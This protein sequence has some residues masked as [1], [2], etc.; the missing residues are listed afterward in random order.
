MGGNQD[1]VLA[2]LDGVA[3]TARTVSLS[4]V[5][6]AGLPA[7]VTVPA[8]VVYGAVAFTPQGVD[9]TVAATV[10]A[11]HNAVVRTTSLTI[12]PANL[13]TFY[14]TPATIAGGNNVAGVVRLDGFAG[15]GGRVVTLSSPSANVV[16]PATSTVASQ[17]TAKSFT[18]TTLG[19]GSTTPV[20]CSATAGAVVKNATETLT[21]AVVQYAQPST[22]TPT[23]GTSFTVTVR[24]TGKAGPGGTTFTLSD[25]SAFASTPASAT[26]P[27]GQL[28]VAFTVTTSPVG[29]NTP[30][31]ITCVG[32]AGV[33]TA[34]A[35]V[36]LTP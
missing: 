20:T 9:S 12:N 36:T 33:G 19:V 24:L 30:V 34:A 35:N 25:N 2:R 7:T 8:G 14:F 3:A 10:T 16:V 29:A 32:P 28:A 23:G 22:T 26:V 11:T 21:R 13:L 31:T 5:A 17:T 27:A 6:A 18:V 1:V 15:P 4:S